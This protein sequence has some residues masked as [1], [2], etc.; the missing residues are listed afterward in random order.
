MKNTIKELLDNAPRDIIEDSFFCSDYDAEITEWDDQDTI[1]FKNA[2][3]EAGITAE[4]KD[5]YGG[6][7]EGDDFWSVYAF[8]KGDETVYVKF[9]GWYA[10][11]HGREFNEWFFVEPKQKTITV[12]EA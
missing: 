2:L 7:G 9:Q 12:Y 5:N 3:S 8:C 6:E 10:S 11:Y 1:E 4:H